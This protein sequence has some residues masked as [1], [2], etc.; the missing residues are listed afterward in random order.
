M[1]L[2]QAHGG[3]PDL[4]RIEAAELD[5]VERFDL[6]F[7][8]HRSLRRFGRLG[9]F[10]FLVLLSDL[11]LISAGPGSCYL[12]GSTGPLF[13][14]QKLRGRRSIGR[15]EQLAADLAQRMSVSP[16]ALE[17]ALCNWQ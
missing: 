7:E 2:A 5:T 17:D 10:D 4:L 16:M 13:G 12:E 15:F 6:L 11:R 14:A 1:T 8:R 9:R 3:P